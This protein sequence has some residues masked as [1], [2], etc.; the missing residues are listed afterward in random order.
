MKSASISVFEIK[1]SCLGLP[2]PMSLFV[3]MVLDYMKAG[4][5]DSGNETKDHSS[6][7]SL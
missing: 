7:F 2:S 6:L 3:F 5:L 1:K 4:G